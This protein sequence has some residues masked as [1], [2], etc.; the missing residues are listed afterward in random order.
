MAI[1]HA[2]CNMAFNLAFLFLPPTTKNLPA[3]PTGADTGRPW[4]WVTVAGT[5][6]RARSW[7][8]PVSVIGEPGPT[9]QINIRKK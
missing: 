6:R 1:K 5:R 2:Q 4:N 7:S 8:T 3:A 9:S